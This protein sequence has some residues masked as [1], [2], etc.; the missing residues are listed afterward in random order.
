MFSKR[1]FTRFPVGG[2]YWMLWNY[3]HHT[4]INNWALT[5]NTQL[6]EVRQG[7]VYYG[8]KEIFLS[9]Y[10]QPVLFYG[11]FDLE[12]PLLPYALHKAILQ[13]LKADVGE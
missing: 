6:V 4:E 1:G 11:P 10:V 7:K 5:N 8:E 2:F 9:E 12:Q 3:H 13:E